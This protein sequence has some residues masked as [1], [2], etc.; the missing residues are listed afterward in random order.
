MKSGHNP[1]GH[2]NSA[3]KIIG[4]GGYQSD[5]VFDDYADRFIDEIRTNLK[6][7]QQEVYD[8]TF[9]RKRLTEEE[10]ASEVHR[11]YMNLFYQNVGD[12]YHF[13][14][15]STCF[16]CLRELPEHPLPCGHVLCTPCV[17]AYGQQYEKT[18]IKLDYCPL[19]LGETEF[20]NDFP[21]RIKVKPLHAGTRILSLD[22]YLQSKLMIEAKPC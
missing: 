4:A 16:S 21:W 6:K 1:K 15:H 8:L 5:F 7:I 3:G 13:V 22:G 14:S 10:A 2:Q 18:V 9:R 12:V 19:H 17:K 20:L 11:Q